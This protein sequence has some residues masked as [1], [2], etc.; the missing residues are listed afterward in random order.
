MSAP[1][2]RGLGLDG[3]GGRLRRCSGR[4][5]PFGRTADGFETQFG[6]NHLGHFV[7]VNSIAS[8][9]A[10]GGRLVNVSGGGPSPRQQIVDALCRWMPMRG[11]VA[12]ICRRAQQSAAART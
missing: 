1:R 9:I 11:D 10:P 5:P 6:T 2:S 12:Q 7:L 4:R 8:L 3:K